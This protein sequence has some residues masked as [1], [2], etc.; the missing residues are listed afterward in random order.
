M[1]ERKEIGML[2]NHQARGDSQGQLMSGMIFDCARRYYP[3][4]TIKALIDVLSGRE[5]AFLQLHLTDNQNVGVECTFLGQTA[6]DAE[7]LPDGSCRNPLT[8]RQFLSAAQIRDI[9]AYAAERGVEIIPEIEA[10]AHMK[11]F[12]ELA[13][14]HFD[15]TYVDSIAFSRWDYPG[16]LDITSA[17]AIWFVRK[18]YDE[19]AAL[20]KDCR[21]FHIGCDELFSGSAA[22]KTSYIRTM[23]SYMRD[24]GYIVR[25]WND[26]LT[27]DNI[28]ELD[29]GIQVTYW[30]W[31]G[32]AQ[33]PERIAS[34]R[35]T[36]ASVPDLQAEGFDIL[37]CNSYY[38]YYV[39][40][41][42]NFNTH[43][44]DY[45]I[46]DLRENWNLTVWDSNKGTALPDTSHIIGSA[47]SMWNEDS[48]E[49]RGERIIAQFIRQYRAMAEVTSRR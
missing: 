5:G 1:D 11:G 47:V 28:P 12:F 44:N 36:R 45:T 22:D 16:E 24:K 39:P 30:S 7:L 32:D 34:R 23:S 31:D 15:S 14:H 29:R 17:D 26:L 46:N 6:E 21:Y 40:S 9:L 42:R 48:A 18:L 35:A 49:L 41:V 20:F 25:L 38:L 33:N 13:E 10:P 2:E 3:V 4:D 37:I 43:D 19:Y 27:K 8:G